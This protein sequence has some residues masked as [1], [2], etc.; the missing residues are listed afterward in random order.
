MMRR[1]HRRPVLPYMRP[2][3]TRQLTAAPSPL[4]EELDEPGA[5]HIQGVRDPDQGD[6]GDESG[7]GD[8]GL[9]VSVFLRGRER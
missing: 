5:K 9:D 2:P 6:E 7:V 8:D 1:H 4:G 3:H